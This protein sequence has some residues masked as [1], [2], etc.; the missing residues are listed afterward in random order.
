MQ[1][2][3]VFIEVLHIQ[4]FVNLLTAISS[5]DPLWIRQFEITDLPI[6]K[7]IVVSQQISWKELFRR[8]S[9][10]NTDLIYIF[11]LFF[12]W[13][14]NLSTGKW[15]WT[16]STTLKATEISVSED[17]LTAF[18]PTVAG[19]NPAAMAHAPLTRRRNAYRL[20]VTK[21]GNW[22]GIGV[23]DGHFILSG[24]NTLGTQSKGVNSSYF[25]QNTG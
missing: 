9:M 13:R 14:L 21:L 12:Y 3:V 10:Y 16:N 1:E 5:E 18:R 20:E 7:H 22:I 6:A 19:R 2:I 8:I 23:A 11:I 25:F 24:S 17:G 4:Y 15:K